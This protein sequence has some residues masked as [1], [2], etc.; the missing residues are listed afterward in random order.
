M[1]NLL[2]NSLATLKTLSGRLASA[3]NLD[4]A[5]AKVSTL[6]PANTALS[7]AIWTNTKAGYLDENISTV[8]SQSSANTAA[9]VL[10]TNMDNYLSTL[11]AS[12]LNARNIQTGF[13]GTLGSAQALSDV[14]YKLYTRVNITP[15]ADASKCFVLVYGYI[16]APALGYVNAPRA[17]TTIFGALVSSNVLEISGYVY[18]QSGQTASSVPSAI[19]WKVIE[20]I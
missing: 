10:V 6:A 1:M 11:L 17:N 16:D 14:E 4:N 8:A 20:L 2:L 15:V 7:T 19:Q 5:N 3:I 18:L 12:I 9:S 13:V